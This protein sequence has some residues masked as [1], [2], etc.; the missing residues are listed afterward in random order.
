M[1][2]PL[3]AS[4][5]SAGSPLVAAQGD[6]LRAEPHACFACGELNEHGIKLQMHVAAGGG[7]WTELALSEQFQG[8][9]GIVHGGIISTILDE[10]GSWALIAA[11]FWGVTVRL[12][13]EFKRPLLVGQRIRAEGR[14]IEIRRRIGRAACRIVDAETGSELAAA[15]GTWLLV[16]E[17]RKRELTARYGGLAAARRQAGEQ[18]TEAAGSIR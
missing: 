17:A 4:E 9:E 18:V 6:L 2:D 3:L 16:D 1:S 14:Q 7:V 13:V 12:N 8:Y 15:E 10:V 11:D 5:W